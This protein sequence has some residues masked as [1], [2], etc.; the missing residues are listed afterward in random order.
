MS[1]MTRKHVTLWLRCIVCETYS[2]A[3]MTMKLHKEVDHKNMN[4]VQIL[5]LFLTDGTDLSER[6]CSQLSG[7]RPLLDFYTLLLLA[8]FFYRYFWLLLALFGNF[9]QLLPTVS[10]SW[11]LL[12]TFGYFFYFLLLLF[13]F[14]YF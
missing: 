9:W 2:K 1:H 7:A 3:S 10:Y 4:R 13:T 8:T 11:L 6:K 5:H 12:A 14:G